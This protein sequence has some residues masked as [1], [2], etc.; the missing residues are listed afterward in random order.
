MA[1]VKLTTPI[2][3]LR[4]QLSKYDDVYLRMLGGKCIL[5]SKPKRTTYKQ[6]AMRQAFAEKYKG[7]HFDN[8]IGAQSTNEDS[9]NCTPH[10]ILT[11]N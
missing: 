7:K 2:K 4:G 8:F 11:I 6:Q 1:I 3:A 5:Q 9:T 10:T